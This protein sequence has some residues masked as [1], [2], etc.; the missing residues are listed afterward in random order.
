MAVQASNA[1][2]LLG[3]RQRGLNAIQ[4]GSSLVDSIWQREKEKSRL[5]VRPSRGSVYNENNGLKNRAP[6]AISNKHLHYQGV[7]LCYMC[8]KLA[9]FVAAS[10]TTPTCGVSRVTCTAAPGLNLE[11][12]QAHLPTKAY[13]PIFVGLLRTVGLG[14]PRQWRA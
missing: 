3:A 11:R 14:L 8:R 5:L 9:C 2:V 4:R 10:C 12:L 1:V 13:T 7:H 6:I